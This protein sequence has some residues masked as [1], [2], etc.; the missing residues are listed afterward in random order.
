MTPLPGIVVVTVSPAQ[1]VSGAL[2]RFSAI[3]SDATGNPADPG[4]VDFTFG[5]V[6]GYGVAPVAPHTYAF[7]TDAQLVKDGTGLYHVDVDTA[8]I[9]TAIDGQFQG[10][11][12]GSTDSI[13]ASGYATCDVTPP[14]FPL[15]LS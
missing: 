13:E 12:N 6:A 10:T 11:P 9:V 8:G 14:P 7:G 15:P 5:P 4:L 3:F 2:V 1:A